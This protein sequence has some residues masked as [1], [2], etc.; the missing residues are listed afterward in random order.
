MI[1]GD[2]TCRKFFYYPSL[3][4]PQIQIKELY[5]PRNNTLIIAFDKESKETA[6]RLKFPHILTANL[7]YPSEKT[8][9]AS[10][11][12]AAALVAI[13]LLLEENK[14]VL[15]HSPSVTWQQDPR[16]IIGHTG[17]RRDILALP[18]RKDQ[19]G[20]ID[21]RFI[22]FKSNQRTKIF[23]QSAVNAIS[24]MPKDPEVFFEQLLWHYKFRQLNTRLLPPMLTRPLLVFK[25]KDKDSNSST[26]KTSL[27]ICPL[28]E[29]IPP[30]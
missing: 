15:Y 1:C 19:F 16:V 27:S 9:I 3:T 28:S 7:T 8:Y 12:F 14:D 13:Q 18:N 22:Y 6:S 11:V 25:T 30:N 17:R 5:D 10:T 23:L 4:P 24:I 21:I 29:K 20:Q 26:P 2:R